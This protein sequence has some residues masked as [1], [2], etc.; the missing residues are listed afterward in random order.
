MTAAAR[1]DRAQFLS[2]VAAI[3]LVVTPL[4]HAE[5]HSREEREDE[6]EVAQVAEA[7]RAGSGDP[8]DALARALEHVH[9]SGRPEKRPG[10]APPGRGHHSHGP[11]GGASHGSGALGHLGLAVHAAPALPDLELARKVHAAP[12]KVVPQLV[13]SLR[14]LVPKWSQG[15][16]GVC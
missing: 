5:E 11:S 3:G 4:L 15:P 14:Y 2:A 12:A 10:Q 1:R 16:P 13:A 6:A 7:W 9:D 8:L